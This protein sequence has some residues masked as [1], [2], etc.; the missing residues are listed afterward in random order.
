MSL[1][2]C[3]KSLFPRNV[4]LPLA[5]MLSHPHTCSVSSGAKFCSLIQ[6]SLL[7]RVSAITP[8]QRR[9]GKRVG[10]GKLRAVRQT[11]PFML[12]R[13]PVTLSALLSS[14][15]SVIA[16][17]AAKAAY[18]MVA[19]ER[20]T[21]HTG[22]RADGPSWPNPHSEMLTHDSGHPDSTLGRFTAGF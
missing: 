22:A 20:H 5:I 15:V 18:N 12:A 9:Q 3:W 14:S 8:W 10:A 13:L 1:F 2:L 17:F 6:P 16:S 4:A 21:Q 7:Y 11:V 19:N